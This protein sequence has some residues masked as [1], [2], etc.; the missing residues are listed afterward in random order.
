M[1]QVPSDVFVGRL[2]GAE[3]FQALGY[4]ALW[5]VLLLSAAQ[6]V[7]TLAVK[8]VSVQGG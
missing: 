1:I 3:L 8:R 2:V 4:Q 7:V 5:A 6:M